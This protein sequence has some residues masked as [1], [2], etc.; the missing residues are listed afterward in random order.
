MIIEP[1]RDRIIVE[2]I[3]NSFLEPTAYSSVR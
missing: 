1:N 2:R 3:D